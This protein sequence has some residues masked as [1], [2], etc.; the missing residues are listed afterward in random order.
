MTKKIRCALVTQ[1]YYGG[2]VNVLTDFSINSKFL[3]SILNSSLMSYW[4]CTK[5]ESKHLKG[6]YLGFDIPS[7]KEIP[8]KEISPEQQKPFIQLVDQILLITKDKDYLD[9][10][11]KQMK[12][13]KLE[14]EIDSLVYKL[15]DLTPEEIKIVEEFNSKW[16]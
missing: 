11:D 5:F 16:E 12:V 1:Q 14:N 7:V 3:I 2:K 9:N 13:K 6:G 8:V 10:E 15:Y 4:Y